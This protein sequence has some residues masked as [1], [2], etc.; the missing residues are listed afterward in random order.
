MRSYLLTVHLCL[1]ANSVLF[2]KY[3]PVPMSSRLFSIFSSI[4]LI[5]PCFMLMS[6]ILM[7]LSFVQGVEYGSI[8]ILLHVAIQFDQDNLLN[9]QSFINVYFQL[10]F[11]KSC[12]CRCM[13]LFLGLQNYPG[14]NTMSRKTNGIFIV[15]MQMLALKSMMTKLQSREPQRTETKR[16]QIVIPRK[17]K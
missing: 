1:C 16:K 9:M 10:L 12:I 4:S 2:R 6:L 11:Q 14:R 15:Y 5:V 13:S 8:C 3:L 17:I 7:G